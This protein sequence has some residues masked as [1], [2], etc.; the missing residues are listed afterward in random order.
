MIVVIFLRVGEMRKRIEE[1]IRI[2]ANDIHLQQTGDSFC[3]LYVTRDTNSPGCQIFPANLVILVRDA[4]YDINPEIIIWRNG[5]RE[6]VKAEL[7]IPT[8]IVI[9]HV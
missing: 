3:I 7:H 9:H 1:R 6:I 2:T 8:E 5:H 4:Q